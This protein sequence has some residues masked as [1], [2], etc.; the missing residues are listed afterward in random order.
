MDGLITEGDI[1]QNIVFNGNIL[2]KLLAAY[3][4]VFIIDCIMFRSLYIFIEQ[5][6]NT[7]FRRVYCLKPLK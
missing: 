4:L 6:Q 7:L 5:Y 2:K 1:Q 3:C